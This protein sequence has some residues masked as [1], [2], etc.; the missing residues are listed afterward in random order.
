MGRVLYG[1][2]LLLTVS[3]FGHGM[4]IEVVPAK[5]ANVP[6]YGT[7]IVCPKGSVVKV[8]TD[9]VPHQLTRDPLHR[10]II[11]CSFRRYEQKDDTENHI[12]DTERRRKA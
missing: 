10:A 2:L 6:P 7:A 8:Y 12:L 4:E 3:C 5:G 11:V 1:A 9:S